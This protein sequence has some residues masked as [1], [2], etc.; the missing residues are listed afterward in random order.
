MRTTISPTHTFATES[1]L[2]FLLNTY[3]LKLTI[4]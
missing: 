3:L 4:V 2:I 1:T